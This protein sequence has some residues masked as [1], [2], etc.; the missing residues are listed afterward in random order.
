MQLLYY[1]STADQ[2]NDRL[3]AVVRK[4]IPAGRIEIFKGPDDLKERFRTPVEPDSVAIFLVSNRKELRDIQSL[5]GLLT[6]IYVI[7]VLPDLNKATIKTA[8]H[9]L[10]RFLSRKDSDFADLKIVLGKMYVNSQNSQIGD[11]SRGS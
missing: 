4:V 2:D 6:E 11:I 7:L 5:Q 10:P 9:L 1:S 3:D 8:H